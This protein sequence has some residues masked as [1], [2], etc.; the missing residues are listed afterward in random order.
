MGRSVETELPQ[1]RYR[2]GGDE[3]VFVELAEAMSLKVKFMAMSMK[4]MSWMVTYRG[5][6]ERYRDG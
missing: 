3:Y 5:V 4:N 2:Y 1:A 6:V